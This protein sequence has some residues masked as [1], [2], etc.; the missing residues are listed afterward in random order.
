MV[1][2]PSRGDGN[3]RKSL[4]GTFGRPLVRVGWK[5]PPS[6]ALVGKSVCVAAATSRAVRISRT[7]REIVGGQRRGGQEGA[8]ELF[9]GPARVSRRISYLVGRPILE[10]Q[11]PGG[12][13]HCGAVGNRGYD[14]EGSGEMQTR[15]GRQDPTGVEEWE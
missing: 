5:P 11:R 7:W 4:R 14:G 12:G 6:I 10:Q 9:A 3:P 2:E 8:D 15:G 1:V 13:S